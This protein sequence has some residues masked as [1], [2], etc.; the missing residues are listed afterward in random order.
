MNTIDGDLLF[1]SEEGGNL[2][3]SKIT[4]ENENNEIKWVPIKIL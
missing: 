2:L 4:Y 3:V 1:C